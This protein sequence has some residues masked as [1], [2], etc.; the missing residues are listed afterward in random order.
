MDK[1]R[2]STI[3]PKGPAFICYPYVQCPNIWRIRDNQ[4]YAIYMM[5]EDDYPREVKG[6]RF[7]INEP[8]FRLQTIEE[9]KKNDEIVTTLENGDLLETQIQTNKLLMLN[10][11]GPKYD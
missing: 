8:A 4:D 9:T 7:V 3:A 5:K 11:V 6:N 2:F 1:I 10:M